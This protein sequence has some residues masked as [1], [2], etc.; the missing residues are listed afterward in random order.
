MAPQLNFVAAREGAE[1]IAQMFSA[2]DWAARQMIEFTRHDAAYGLMMMGY[3]EDSFAQLRHVSDRDI[4]ACAGR[5]GTRP[6][7][8]FSAA[9]RGCA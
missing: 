1:A 8:T 2:Y 3:V 7:P 4:G 6:P 5:N 9:W